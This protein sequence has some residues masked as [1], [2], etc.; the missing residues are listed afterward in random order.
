MKLPLHKERVNVPVQVRM[1]EHYSIDI[2]QCPCCK[3]KTMQLIQVYNPW[4]HAD[5]G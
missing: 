5:D 4:K 2:Y 3:N 1:M